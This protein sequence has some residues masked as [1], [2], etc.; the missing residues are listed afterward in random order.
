MI[1]SELIQ[2][3]AAKQN[4]LSLEDI[5]HSI[6]HI[7]DYLCQSLAGGQRIEIRGFG[8]FSLRYR[9][10]RQ[11]RNPK[12]GTQVATS[13]KFWP[14]FKMGKDLKDRINSLPPG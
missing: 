8:S 3:V 12:T 4:C 10:P 1:K 14:Y 5:E 6:N 7:F 9:S 2:R 13:A 11:A